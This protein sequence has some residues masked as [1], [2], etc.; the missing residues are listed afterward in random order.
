MPRTLLLSLFLLVT[1]TC[2]FAQDVTIYQIQ[3]TTQPNGD[4]PL[5]DSTVFTGGIVTAVNFQN[6]PIRYFI[7]DRVGGLWGG[8]LVNDNQDRQLAVGDSVRFQ[9][10]VQE[11]SGQTRLR[12]IVSGTFS[13]VPQSASPTTALVAT[14][15][16]NESTEGVLVEFTDAVV[17]EIGADEFTVNDGSGAA[18]IGEGWPY[19]YAP[20]VGD[21]LRYLR[22]V[23]SSV[24]NVYTVNPRSDADFGFFG[25]RPPLISNV[26]NSPATPTEF[27]TDTITAFVVDDDGV[28]AAQLHYRFGEN[29]DFAEQE[30]HDDGTHGDR[31]GGDGTWTG[32]IPAGPARTVAYYYLCASDAEGANGCSPADAPATTYTYDIRGSVLGIYDLQYTGNPTGGDSPYNGQVVTVTGIVTGTQFG[33]FLDGFFIADPGGGLWSG[34][35]VFNPQS[36]PALADS[37]RITG[38]ITEYNGLTEFTAGAEVTVLGQGVLP[39]PLTM[40]FTQ[41]A[42]SGEPFEGTL[43]R[44]D[45]PMRVTDVSDWSQYRQFSLS[46]GSVTA[47]ASGSFA[48]GN[49]AFEYVPVEGDS[50]MWMIGCVTYNSNIGW[51]IAPRS[52]A[53]IGYLDHRAPQLVDVQAISARDVNVQFSERLDSEGLS[54]LSNYETVDQTDPEFPILQLESAYLFSSG[55]IVHLTYMNELD[56]EHAYRLTIHQVS[57]TAGNA[58]NETVAT[59]GGYEPEGLTPIATLYDSFDV[60]NGRIVTLRGVVNFVQ[61]VTTTSGSRRI[62]AYM[63]D[64]SGRGFSLSQTGPAASFPNIQRGNW[65]RMTGVVNVFDGT[66]QLGSFT[67]ADAVLLSEHVPLPAPIVVHTGEYREQRRIVHVNSP[68]AYGAGTWVQT[69]GTIYRVDENVGGGTNIAID[70]GTG[71]LTIRIWDS[72]NL[73]SV[74]LNGE[75]YL[76]HELVGKYVTVSGPSSTYSGD[77]QMLAG[78]AEDFSAPF[79][80]EQPSESTM[81]D[82]PKHAFAPDLGQTLQISYN[83]PAL[84]E[85]R[86]RIFDLRGRLVRTLVTKPAGGPGVIDWDGR[87]ELRDLVPMGTYILHLES[88]KGGK[89][90]VKTKPI[91]VGTKL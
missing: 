59:F 53:E 11:S 41:L 33:S 70:D 40:R 43:A 65:I 62:S 38:E 76:M 47:A 19:S 50:I 5:R 67:A 58:L 84:G 4:S 2:A 12:N 74:Q 68:G 71:N 42:D 73:D 51:M 10:Q 88:V 77:F 13:T 83:S 34:V 1:I 35:E 89:S 45:A 82:V 64:E 90:D 28:A 75:W 23:V 39:A 81:L 31:S 20:L 46:S 69:S 87:N 78:Y 54:A 37:I 32:V 9:A 57:D 63:Q 48:Y 52:D 18:T 85:V 66:I 14:G 17:T 56:P 26:L 21:T 91:V 8:I 6:Q 61:D 27:E 25:N 15:D 86:L 60:Y 22:G 30:M 36:T 55:R 24:N 80:D 29:G 72:M 7:A 16:I 49:P 79:V 3:F 44:V